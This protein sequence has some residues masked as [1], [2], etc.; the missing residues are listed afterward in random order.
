MAA[1]ERARHQGSNEE[2]TRAVNI[3]NDPAI[4]D[5]DWDLD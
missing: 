4:S 1:M 3:H 5:I 2:R